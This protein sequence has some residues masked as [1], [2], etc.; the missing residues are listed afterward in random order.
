MEDISSSTKTLVLSDFSKTRKE[1]KQKEPKHKKKVLA[2]T[3]E[4]DQY[5]MENL[6]PAAQKHA[7]DEA[8]RMLYAE[9]TDNKA[10]RILIR[11]IK[12]K[13]AGYRAQDTDKGVLDMENFIG[14]KDILE[15]LQR[16][17]L[18]CFYCKEHTH[19]FYEYCR[20][21]KQWTLERVDNAFGHNRD[22]VEI[23]CLQCNIRR[24]TMF[25]ERYQM[26]KQCVI[27]KRD[28]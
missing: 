4:W 18:R 23:A 8:L 13:Q 12:I 15:K 24:R 19:V 9:D 11:L 10:A 28:A 26:T 5:I 25:Y 17:E 21:P 6:S 16:S 3:D 2:Q 27:T 1:V 14:I 22:N 7:T 20:D